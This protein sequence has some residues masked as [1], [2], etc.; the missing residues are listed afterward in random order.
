[1]KK[2]I[3]IFFDGIGIGPASGSNPFWAVQS[4]YLPL[5]KGAAT[6]QMPFLFKPLPAKTHLSGSCSSALHQTALFCGFEPADLPE[7]RLS[8]PDHQLRQII[9]KNNILKT[10]KSLGKKAVF[11][12]AYPY[13]AELFQPPHLTFTADG[14]LLFSEKFP[15]RFRKKISVTTCMMLSVGQQPFDE[16]AI[17]QRKT[18]YH[19]FS[20][21]SLINSGMELPFFSPEDAAAILVQECRN[22]DFLLY[23]FFLTDLI[24]HR[25]NFEL[26]CELIKHLERF[27]QNLMNRIDLQTTTV[28]VTSDH[29]NL[30]DLS[31]PQHTSHPVPLIICGKNQLLLFNQ[32]SSL[33]NVTPAIVDS[34]RKESPF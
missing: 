2:L 24:G 33:G 3:F 34:F 19:D 16:Q 26:A 25:C 31:T 15:Q 23:E 20:N 27:I 21:Q 12:N 17:V 18:L 1:M 29:G 28:L 4:R 7:K 22:S 13:H 8:F 9:F 14:S 32:I 10:L 11:F 5:Y 30:E 6:D